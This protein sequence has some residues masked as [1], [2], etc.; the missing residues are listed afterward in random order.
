MHRVLLCNSEAACYVKIL[1][2]LW[3]YED[4]GLISQS[5]LINDIAVRALLEAHRIKFCRSAVASAFH[6]MFITS[7]KGNKGILVGTI[8]CAICTQKDL[9]SVWDEAIVC[10]IGKSIL[11]LN[12]VE[13]AFIDRLTQCTSDDA[14]INQKAGSLLMCIKAAFSCLYFC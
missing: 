3:E 5:S 11:R 1:Q 10:G 14:V 12:V 8:L 4:Q 9:L 13:L 6:S 7:S 2:K